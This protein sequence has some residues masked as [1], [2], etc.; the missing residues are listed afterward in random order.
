[1]Q[2]I[3]FYGSQVMENK[4]I[5]LDYTNVIGQITEEEIYNEQNKVT[6]LHNGIENKKLDGSEYL[7]WLDLPE[8]IEETLIEDIIE[9]SQK[10]KD[11][12]D[13]FIVI[14]IGGSYLGAKAVNS[15]LTH[16]FYEALPK[17]FKLLPEVVFAGQNLS[18]DYIADLLDLIID[19][20]VS[21]NVISKSGTTTEPAIAFR[22]ILKELEKLYGVNEANRRIFVTTDKDKGALKQLANEKGYKSFVIPDDV[23]GRYSVLTPVGLLPIAVAGHNIRE[24]LQGAKDMRNI[25]K[26]P[27]LRTNPAYLYATVRNL[28]LKKDKNIEI[29]SYFS[30]KMFYFAEWWK[31]LYGESEGKDQKGIFPASCCF[32]SDLHSMG[33]YI[34]DGRRNLFET[35]IEVENQ[36]REVRIPFDNQ[37]LDK[38]NYLHNQTVEHVN[39]KAYLGTA[40]AHKDGGVP[41]MSIILPELSPYYLGQLIYFYEKACAL[42]GYSI[43]V[44]PFNQPGVEAYKKN[45]F[46]L[47]GKEGFENETKTLNDELDNRKR[48]IV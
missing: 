27:N 37:N 44:N 43:D 7:G 3:I 12:S 17:T 18:S 40:L 10:I 28:L 16:T 4:R 26:D 9:T 21:V 23:G 2:T 46:A 20:R 24:L 41:N 1:M 34:Q 47:L 22:I 42:S 19:K 35:F 25:L 36:K 32:T 38:L 8:K 45:M 31:Q 39:Y 30:H 29:M 33:Q 48:Y 14:G 11:S 5:K 13:T 6:E 15:A